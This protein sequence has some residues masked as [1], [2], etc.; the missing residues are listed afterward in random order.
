ML[1]VENVFCDDELKVQADELQF[2]N[3]EQIGC[4]NTV[5]TLKFLVG[6]VHK[7]T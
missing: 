7:Y 3:G 2:L 6:T 4:L 1:E 5:K